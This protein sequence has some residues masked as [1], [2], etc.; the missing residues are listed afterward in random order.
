MDWKQL[1]YTIPVPAR[2]IE[3]SRLMSKEIAKAEDMLQR[4]LW[5][6]ISGEPYTP[7]EQAYLDRQREIQDRWDN[8]DEEYNAL[9]DAP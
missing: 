8:A 2:A 7:E 1:S 3:F 4:L 5:K 9:W 6:Q